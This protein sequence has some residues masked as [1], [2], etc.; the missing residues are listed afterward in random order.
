MKGATMKQQYR[1]DM[2]MD[3]IMRLWPA[4]IHVTLRHG[5]LCVGCPFASFHTVNDAIVE[6]GLAEEPFRSELR[7]AI[8]SPDHYLFVVQPPLGE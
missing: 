8:N 1:D 6:H 3:E 4:T 7:A 5:L 2:A